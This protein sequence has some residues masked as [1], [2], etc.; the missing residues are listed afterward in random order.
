M[1]SFESSVLKRWLVPYGLLRALSLA[2][3]SQ[4]TPEVE[5]CVLA[6]LARH[7]LKAYTAGEKTQSPAHP[8][9]QQRLGEASTAAEKQVPAAAAAAVAAPAAAAL[10][11]NAS[12]EIS[13]CSEMQSSDEEEGHGDETQSDDSMHGHSIVGTDNAQ[14]NTCHR[15]CAVMYYVDCKHD[16]CLLLTCLYTQLHGPCSYQCYCCYCCCYPH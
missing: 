14:V 1:G 4:G 5:G 12:E 7:L 8:Q 13:T 2:V 3:L 10:A 16:V 9:A 15:G 6:D 11:S